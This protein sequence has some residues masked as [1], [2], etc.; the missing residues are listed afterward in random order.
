MRWFP[1]WF[2]NFFEGGGGFDKQKTVPKNDKKQE[3]VCVRREIQ[4]A[5]GHSDTIEHKVA[6]QAFHGPRVHRTSQAL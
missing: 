4:I 6:L 2:W 3:K 5:V 1:E